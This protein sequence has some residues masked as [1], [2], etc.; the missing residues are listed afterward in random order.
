MWGNGDI[1]GY[2]MT[3]NTDHSYLCKSIA[4]GWHDNKCMRRLGVDIKMSIENVIIILSGKIF[5]LRA[6]SLR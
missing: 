5:E 3:Q 1:H 4:G 2:V 6:K